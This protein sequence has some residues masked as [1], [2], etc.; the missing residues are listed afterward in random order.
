MV[1]QLIWNFQNSLVK[2]IQ[3]GGIFDELLVALPYAALKAGTQELVKRAP[4]LTKDTT[5]YFVDKRINGLK[6]DFIL[7]AGSGITLTNNEI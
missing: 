5:R 4:E 2:K 7:S 6:K 1:H 3:S